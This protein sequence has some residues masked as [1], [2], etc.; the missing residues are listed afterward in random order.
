MLN[1]LQAQRQTTNLKIP[2]KKNQLDE[3]TKHHVQE[4]LW[5]D[6]DITQCEWTKHVP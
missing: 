1:A 5:K 4:K 6:A 3:S 2:N